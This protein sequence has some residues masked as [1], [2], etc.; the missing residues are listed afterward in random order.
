MFDF[1]NLNKA[2]II[3]LAVSSFC[4][5]FV[6]VSTLVMLFSSR[7]MRLTIGADF[8]IR[9]LLIIVVGLSFGYGIV[10]FLLCSITKA[11][12]IKAAGHAFLF[13]ALGEVCAMVIAGLTLFGDADYQ[14]NMNL[15]ED[16]LCIL[17]HLV[18]GVLALFG[19]TFRHSKKKMFVA[20]LIALIVTLLLAFADI[21]L[22]GPSTVRAQS[23]DYVFVLSGLGSVLPYLAA[24]IFS[25]TL[26][27]EED[28]DDEESEKVA[29]V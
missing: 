17:F 19:W 12:P 21:F 13:F 8:V 28:V 26:A 18:I 22:I 25:R 9:W 15:I 27:I 5:L 4:L 1:K 24:V 2:K 14:Q 7:Y 3:N 29:S 6:L 16:V 20:S 10:R 11:D 23:V